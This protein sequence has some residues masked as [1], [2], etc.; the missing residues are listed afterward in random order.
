MGHFFEELHQGKVM[1]AFTKSQHWEE[2]QSER[3]REGEKDQVYRRFERGQVVG[4]W[5]G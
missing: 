4:F 3:V 1:V 5:K 2:G